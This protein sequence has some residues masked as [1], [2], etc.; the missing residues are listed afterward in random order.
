MVGKGKCVGGL[1]ACTKP[2]LKHLQTDATIYLCTVPSTLDK[3]PGWFQAAAV[4]NITNKDSR[5][6][7]RRDSYKQ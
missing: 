2:A 5:Y 6:E 3:I 4:T 1:C 7:G